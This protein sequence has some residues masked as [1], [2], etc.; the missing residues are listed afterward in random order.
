MISRK[1]FQDLLTD[2]RRIQIDMEPH[3][4]YEYRENI[5]DKAWKYQN[6]EGEQNAIYTRALIKTDQGNPFIEALPE[7]LD[8]DGIKKH[9]YHAMAETPD[10][11]ASID[12]Q[13][14]QVSLIEDIRFP[15]PFT[16][17]LERKFQLAMIT[18][19]RHRLP[20]ITI[21]KTTVESGYKNI[22]Q[23]V[24]FKDASGADSGV[25]FPLLGVSG[26]GKSE[27]VRKMLSRYPQLI[28][29][30]WP[31][32]GSFLQIVYISVITAANSNLQALYQSIAQAVDQALGHTDKQIYAEEMKKH[33]SVS[34]KA[35]Y[36]AKLV[37]MFAIGAII[38]D[39]IQQLDAGRNRKTSYSSILA[40]TNTTKVALIVIG[41]DEAYKALTQDFY[42]ARRF[43]GII[44]A[45]SYCLDRE[46]FDSMAKLL[47]KIN[48]FKEPLKITNELLDAMYA[49]SHGVISRMISVWQ[50]CNSAYITSKG[51]AQITAEF[52]RM[53]SNNAAPTM[54]FHTARAVENDCCIF[55]EKN[56]AFLPSYNAPAALTS[57][58]NPML[59]NDVYNKAREVSFFNDNKYSD[60]TILSTVEAVM[61]RKD[62][63]DLGVTEL[64]VK[65]MKILN[66]KSSD[67][68]TKQKKPKALDLDT[69]RAEIIAN[70]D[71]DEVLSKTE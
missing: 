16:V 24:T 23:A 61:N 8:T 6:S 56:T 26:C 64:V 2:T 49:E 39:E 36:A 47:M 11:N 37:E 62:I 42:L 71:I 22:T 4:I 7:A 29:H 35:Q 12:A 55:N 70:E 46:R 33:K 41:T 44:N 40:L 69:L 45:S 32:K 43:G 51:K 1:S 31:G 57:T 15:L 60:A 19:Y 34:E 66:N 48:W 25:G 53:A 17:E 9:Y 68:R 59:A 3:F 21:G 63:N 13:L 27:T 10:I 20:F 18:S 14:Q 5:K 30:S 28:R 50:A 58:P 52:I 67:R 65:V 54:A 38:L